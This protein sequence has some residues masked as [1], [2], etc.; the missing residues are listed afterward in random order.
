[1]HAAGLQSIPRHTTLQHITLQLIVIREHVHT[2]K[3][4]R[5]ITTTPHT[6]LFKSLLDTT[7]ADF[8]DMTMRRLICVR[9]KKK[10][11]AETDVR[12]RQQRQQC[13]IDAML[14]ERY[15]SMHNTHTA[16]RLTRWM[17]L[18]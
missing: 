8:D 15:S 1:M 9:S 13:R 7:T 17:L 5:I 12:K 18:H 10:E 16:S 3:T 14:M 2:K 6:F 4:P 11:K